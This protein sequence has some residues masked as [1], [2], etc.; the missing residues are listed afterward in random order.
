MTR[1]T[2]EEEKAEN[3]KQL[4]NRSLFLLLYIIFASLP[5][6]P[7][8]TVAYRQD[9]E[10]LWFLGLV[11][12]ICLSIPAVFILYRFLKS[13]ISVTIDEIIKE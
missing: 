9:S 4:R 5:L 10:Y 6:V 7:I 11:I 13:I 2:I 12:G 3:I 8:L 1:L